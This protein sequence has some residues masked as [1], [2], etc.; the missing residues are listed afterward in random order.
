M[1]K[2]KRE[3]RYQMLIKCA[4]RK[5]LRQHLNRLRAHA[6]ANRWG[7]TALVGDVDPLSLL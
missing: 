2:L 7:A 6:V 1:P 5:I 4:S 3:F